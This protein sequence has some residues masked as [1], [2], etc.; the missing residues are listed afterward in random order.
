MIYFSYIDHE[1]AENITMRSFSTT[2]I[3][4]IVLFNNG[5]LF[6]K[7]NGKVSSTFARNKS[8]S[9]E[10]PLQYSFRKCSFSEIGNKTVGT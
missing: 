3:E 1:K 9:Q 4:S 5:T 2:S 8:S 7:Q 6:T 10:Q